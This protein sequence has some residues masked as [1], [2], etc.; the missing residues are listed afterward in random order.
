MARWAVAVVALLALC[1]P[2]PAAAQDDCALKIVRP[3]AVGV[4]GTGLDADSP[5]FRAYTGIPYQF[6]LAIR[7]GT[8]EEYEVSVANAPTG[9]TIADTGPC[10]TQP[11]DHWI[12]SWPSPDATATD[13]EFT[14]TDADESDSVTITIAV[15]SCTPGAGGCCAINADTGNNANAG[16]PAAP[17][18]TIA[19]A[20]S[21][22]GARSIMYLIGGTTASYNLAGITTTTGQCYSEG[23]RVSFTEAS[24]PVAW[25][26]RPDLAPAVIDWT[27]GSI[28]A[29]C[30]QLAGENVWLQNLDI[31]N[32]GNITFQ[33]LR[34]GGFGVTV[35]D[36]VGS[37]F[38]PGV[39]LPGGGGSNPGVFDFPDNSFTFSYYDVLQNITLSDLEYGV[40]LVAV[41][42]YFMR[43]PLFEDFTITDI[44]GRVSERE[45]AFGI[46]DGIR[47]I[48]IRNVY[49]ASF[50]A[51]VPCIAGN[52]DNGDGGQTT[53]ARYHHVWAN[54][55]SGD[56]I[57]IGASKVNAIGSVKLHQN[58]FVGTVILANLATGD[59]PV[60]LSQNV[61][62]NS[63]GGGS[64][65]CPG[66]RVTCNHVAGSVTDYTTITDAGN[67]LVGAN[68]GAIV[69][70]TTGAL[71]GAYLTSYGPDTATPRGHTLPSAAGEPIGGRPRIRG[72]KGL[73]VQ[74]L[75]GI[76]GGGNTISAAQRQMI[77]AG[78][79]TR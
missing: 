62:V 34:T 76:G 78:F 47:D 30:A 57:H 77:K 18:Q 56:A 2:E 3:L 52:M 58:T 64:S 65:P 46:K 11:C 51:E 72:G 39:E 63:G 35:F 53:S 6:R 20:R 59:G 48:E 44:N 26:G 10:T 45:G 13:V 14:V 71:Q 28:T 32:G 12:V 24:H 41:K 15:A 27:G 19:Y 69:S 16:T 33:F 9:M 66:M 49:C 54:L 29:P 21:N 36:I 68:D 4:V 8:Y 55:G 38:G 61:I 1:A 73:R 31:R 22:C 25:I 50:P 40:G 17:W 79:R 5:V 23:D 7:C 37:A 67:N 70:T 74:L 43:D 75:D 60:T 42:T